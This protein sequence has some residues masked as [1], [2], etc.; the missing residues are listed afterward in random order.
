MILKIIS[1]FLQLPTAQVEY[2]I[3]LLIQEGFCQ[4]IFYWEGAQYDSKNIKN[5]SDLIEFLQAFCQSQWFKGHDRLKLPDNITSY[6]SK[7]YFSL[8]EGFGLTKTFSYTAQENPDFS[9]ILGSTELD[10]RSRVDSLKNDLLK[11]CWP[12]QNLIF[13][14]G[15]NR[16]LGYSPLELEEESKRKLLMQNQKPTE[17]N[18]VTMQT[19]EMLRDLILEDSTFSRLSYQAINTAFSELKS[20]KEHRIITADTASSLKSFVENGS[21][22][23]EKKSVYIAIY[24]NQPYILRQHRDI[25]LTLGPDYKVVGVGAAL[26]EVDFDCND[27]SVGELFGEIARLVNIN[28]KADHLKNFDIALTQAEIDKIGEIQQM[29]NIEPSNYRFKYT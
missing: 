22:F 2:L 1:D 13:G 25:Q 15:S 16:Q 9:V 14:L 28:Y 23:K 24:S 7:H 29:G 5:Q 18:M 27:K 17:M 21:N 12:K 3:I 26:N 10:T 8:F 20:F 11:G 19:S 4:E 6:K